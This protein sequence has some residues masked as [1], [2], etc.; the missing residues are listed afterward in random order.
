MFHYDEQTS[1]GLYDFVHLNNVRVTDNFQD[2]EL[3]TDTLDVGYFG[4][5]VFFK[6]LDCDLLLSEKMDSFLYLSEG[7]LT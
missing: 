1:G 5:F 2:M 7:A 4:N 6:N 3:A